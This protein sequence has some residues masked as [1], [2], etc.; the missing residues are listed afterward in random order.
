M[1]N[2]NCLVCEG[3]CLT[4]VSSGTYCLKCKSLTYL[5]NNKCNETC[6]PT[7]FAENGL[8]VGCSQ[9]CLTC[10]NQP[11]NC[12]KCNPQST[13]PYLLG[14]SCLAKC[15]PGYFSNLS[16]GICENCNYPCA[17]C[18]T[19]VLCESCLQTKGAMYLINNN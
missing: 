4:C 12:T 19:S 17:T 7:L 15:N 11:N 10:L 9:P 3:S 18:S 2:T 8:C 14:N 16:S 1:Q 13:T 5:Y 6:P